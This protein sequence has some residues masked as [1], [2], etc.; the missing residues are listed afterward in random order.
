MNYDKKKLETAKSLILK[1]REQASELIDGTI[2]DLKSDRIILS[3]RGATNQLLK[4]MDNAIAL[5]ENAHKS[6]L[7]QWAHKYKFFRSQPNRIDPV[8]NNNNIDAVIKFMDELDPQIK[9][10]L[11]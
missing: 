5:L 11:G 7:A 4:Y 6:Y 8:K 9:K 2:S 1:N 10:A 3:E